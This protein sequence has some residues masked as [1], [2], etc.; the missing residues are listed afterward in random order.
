[1]ANGQRTLYMDVTF[2]RV[3]WQRATTRVPNRILGLSAVL[4]LLVAFAG[5]LY[6]TQASAAAEMRYQLESREMEQAAL[7]EELASLRCQ[8]AA[9]ECLPVVEQRVAQLGLVDAP[10]D[11]PVAICYIPEHEAAPAAI[12]SDG[13]PAAPRPLANDPWLHILSLLGLT[14]Q[15]S[16]PTA[17]R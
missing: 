16:A 14:G 17:R 1:M 3:S 15:P 4:L 13:L 10:L 7:Q 8:I 5:L 6:L 9:R 12:E 2:R 11:Q